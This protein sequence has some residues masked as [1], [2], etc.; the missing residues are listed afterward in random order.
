VV[1]QPTPRSSL[2]ATVSRSF[3][4]SGE[5]LSLAANAADLEPEESRNI[6]GGAKAELFGA[7]ATATVS[8]FQLDRSNIKTTDPIDPTKLVLVGRQRTSG[9]ELSFEGRILDRLR[10]QAGYAFLDA[11][12]LRSNT[13]SSGVRIEGNRPGLVPRHAANLWLHYGLSSRLAV[14]GGV[15]TSGMRFTSNDDLVILPAYTRVDA[16]ASYSVGRVELALNVRN[17]AGTRYYETAGSNFQIYPGT[18]R[19]VV[20]TLRVGR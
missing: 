19:D 11:A 14:T 8:V 3:Q 13:V 15:T 16:G 7:R 5:G 10:A 17:L 9:V 18:P 12:V 20:L 2:Y 4:P 1:F 6:E